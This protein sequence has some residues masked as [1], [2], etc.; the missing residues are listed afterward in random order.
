MWKFSLYKIV[1][2]LQLLKI[3]EGEKIIIQ[4]AK[5]RSNK[6]GTRMKSP[7]YHINVETS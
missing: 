1:N 5:D 4:I 6:M 2:H 3:L 7:V